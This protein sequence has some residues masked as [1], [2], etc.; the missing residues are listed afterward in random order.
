MIEGESWGNMLYFLDQ[1]LPI[2]ILEMIGVHCALAIKNI[3]SLELRNNE[4]SVLNRIANTTSK[5]LDTDA[6]LNNTINEI[7]QIYHADVAL[8]HLWNEKERTLKLASHYGVPNA[9][10]NDLNISSLKNSP[11]IMFFLSQMNM[12]TGVIEDYLSLFPVF[13]FNDEHPHHQFLAFIINFGET[14]YG[15]MT[16]ARAGEKQFNEEEK[17]LLASISNQLAVSLENSKLHSVVLRR[18]NEAEAARV[19]LEESIEKQKAAEDKLRESEETYRTIFES[20]NDILL[21]IDTKGKLVDINA[22]IKETGGFKREDMIGKDIRTI[23]KIMTKKSIAIITKNYL[24][25]MAGLTVSPYE[26]EM[27][28]KDGE[29]KVVEISAAALQKNGKI[30]EDLAILRDVTERKQ[31][32]RN[33]KRQK[34]LI[35]RILA[36]IPN[37]VLLLNNNQQIIMANKAF[38]DLFKLVK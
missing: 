33:L 13:A 35:D 28:T 3:N 8:I 16:L 27:I 4:L 30:I 38:Y 14:R 23:S 29:R 24:K 31:A 9:I 21:L 6:L 17:S 1:E 26:V 36:T 37:A 10:K 15:M 25:R 34:N 20:A 19:N 2:D 5:S 11:I 7:V 12:I 32:E 18:M 22:R